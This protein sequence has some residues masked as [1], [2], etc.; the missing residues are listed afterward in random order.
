MMIA[1]TIFVS[2]GAISLAALLAM[3]STRRSP[4]TRVAIGRSATLAGGVAALMAPAIVGRIPVLFPLDPSSLTVGG[5]TPPP[6][7]R[8]GMNGFE[9]VP[10]EITPLDSKTASESSAQVVRYDPIATSSPTPMAPRSFDFTETMLWSLG[11]AAIGG[12]SLLGLATL[13]RIRARSR[14]IESG[15]ASEILSEMW[16]GRTDRRPEL[17]VSDAIAS[18]FL[19]GLLRPAILLPQ[20]LAN[21]AD[22]TTLYGVLS[23]EVS[24][25]NRQAVGWNYASRLVLTALWM[26]PL[27]WWVQ[28]ATAEAEEELSDLDVLRAGCSRQSYAACLVKVA[29]DR[30]RRSPGL[31]VGMAARPSR[32]GRRIEAIVEGRFDPSG[33]VSKWARKAIPAGAILVAG[34][35][36]M[37]IGP[38]RMSDRDSEKAHAL[39][40]KTVDAYAKLNYFEAQIKGRW[41]FGEYHGDFRYEPR[42]RLNLALWEQFRLGTGPFLMTADG[43]NLFAYDPRN[44][45]SYVQ[46]PLGDAD[47]YDQMRK[48]LA[49]SF[50]AMDWF[51]GENA[52][53]MQSV[54][55]AAPM[56]LKGVDVRDNVSVQVLEAGE[57]KPGSSRTTLYIGAK[58][59]LIRQTESVSMDESGAVHKTTESYLN[60]RTT[61]KNPAVPW[62]FTPPKNAKV[63]Y[64]PV[65]EPNTP[66]A[67]AF[68]DEMIAATRSIRSS[69]ADFV[70]TRTINGRPLE[71]KR[72]IEFAGPKARFE[73]TVG[74]ESMLSISDGVRV[75]AVNPANPTV[76]AQRDA[77]K[78]AFRMPYDLAMGAGLPQPVTASYPSLELNYMGAPMVLTLR[79]NQV[80]LEGE[81]EFEGETV[82]VLSSRPYTFKPD[83]TDI[84]TQTLYVSKRDHMIRYYRDVRRSGSHSEVETGVARNVRLNVEIP[85]ERFKIELPPNATRFK[86]GAP[87]KVTERT[88]ERG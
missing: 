14:S 9:P 30:T 45:D 1:A 82:Q 25:L 50:Q 26:Q 78:W 44:R 66:E 86:P 57:L 27:L 54:W 58:D 47:P 40:R 69:V 59:G 64:E 79:Y 41:D 74:K 20:P 77:S 76:Y 3:R 83:A 5:T 60:V 71:T 61:P 37:T 43:K 2:T 6:A 49:P 84:L 72:H 32:L 63:R 19:T 67:R 48:R 52:E 68:I 56:T 87:A 70:V 35:G 15:T 31:A 36:S 28:R 21:E 7:M 88:A 55:Q 73:Q 8:E 29:E 46:A 13:T 39:W 18:P 34:L 65:A 11:V 17:R 16:E 12:Y 85:D 62:R 81:R 53:L 33:T 23:H 80:T 42:R 75:V 38:A 4:A 22:R 10:A 51:F 24:H